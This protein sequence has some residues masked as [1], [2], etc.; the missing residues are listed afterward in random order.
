MVTLPTA[1]CVVGVPE[2]A[3]VVI[4]VEDA[5]DVDADVDAVGNMLPTIPPNR[6]PP[7][8]DVAAGEA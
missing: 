8:E 4:A 6:P 5:V 7:D 3:W 2:V 1:A